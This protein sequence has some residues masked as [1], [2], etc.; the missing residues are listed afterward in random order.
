M[1][2]KSSGKICQWVHNLKAAIKLNS[3][4][5]KFFLSLLI[6][7]HVLNLK[8]CVELWGVFCV[9]RSLIPEALNSW[10]FSFATLT[11]DSINSSCV[12]ACLLH[13]R[14]YGRKNQRKL[15]LVWTLMSSSPGVSSFFLLGQKTNKISPRSL[16]CKADRLTWLHLVCVQNVS[17]CVKECVWCVPHIPLSGQNICLLGMGIQTLKIIVW[18]FWILDHPLIWGTQVPESCT[19]LFKVT[20]LEREGTGTWTWSYASEHSALFFFTCYICYT[21]FCFTLSCVF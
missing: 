10:G 1:W 19:E 8:T 14:R 12:F 9:E 2:K 11:I 21:F 16:I 7:L 15:E 5:L 13:K 18:K 3:Q 17:A 4:V 20:P 6:K